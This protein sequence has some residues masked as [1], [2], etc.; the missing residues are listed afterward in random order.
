[1]RLN[2]IE[3]P[4]LGFGNGEH[5][6]PRAGITNYE[7][8]D[9]RLAARREDLLVGAIGT[10]ETLSKL[11]S[12]LRRCSKPIVGKLNSNQP[13]LFTSFCGFNKDVGFRARLVLDDEITRRINNSSVSSIIRIKDWN[14]R[15][16]EAVKLYYRQVKFLAQ[17]RNVDVIVCVIPNK[18]YE[19]ISKRDS[20]APT[21]ESLDDEEQDDTYEVN[22]RRALKAETMHLG[23]PLQ[24]VIESSLESNPT[25]RQDDATRA[26]NFC[27]ALYYKANQTVPWKLL[28]NANRPSVCFVG[29]GF[30]RSRDRQMLHTSL[31]QV[32]DELGNN[33]ILRGTPVDIDKNDR[34]P[35]LTSEQAYELLKQALLEYE[36]AMDNFPGRLVMHKSSNYN[37][38]ELEGFQEAKNE[39]RISAIDF[40]TILDTDFRLL[41]K[42]IYPPY[43]GTQI[44]IDEKT[45]LLYTRGSVKY[46][47]TYTGKYIPSPIEIRI[48][49]ADES[50]KVICEEIL[51][52]TKMNWN[53]TQFDGKYPITLSC[54]RKVGQ[55][56]KYVD[57]NE[58]PQISYSFYM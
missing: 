58:Q 31:T 55:I 29:L 19:K 13:N 32:F 18:L 6:C 38:A 53:N 44:E 9:T 10:S 41:R 22:F 15:V 23:K 20:R 16:D 4:L 30:Y 39:L 45:H 7:V 42:G 26:W 36:I 28:T 27:T 11:D 46:Y 51:S 17:N 54:A 12:W 25:G 40:V 48:V 24:L 37:D 5:V 50:P 47:K 43:R 21:E 1:M 56:M 52:L 33:V 8:Y 35:H 3:E 49:G 14:K 34:Q 57:E 2:F